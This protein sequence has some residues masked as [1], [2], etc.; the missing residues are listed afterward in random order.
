MTKREKLEKQIR[1]T[2]RYLKKCSVADKWRRFGFKVPIINTRGKCG[3][4]YD[5]DDNMLEM[6]C[7]KCPYNE[8]FIEKQPVILQFEK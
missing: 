7:K 4:C 5:P 2:K 1:D 3:G 8:Y 6:R